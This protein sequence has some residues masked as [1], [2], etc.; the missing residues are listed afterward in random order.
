M[1][2]NYNISQIL[3]KVATER[4]WLDTTGLMHTVALVFLIGP[5]QTNIA[6]HSISL[7][8]HDRT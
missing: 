2:K 4:I 6:V 1:M 8:E 3:T 5:T 7:K